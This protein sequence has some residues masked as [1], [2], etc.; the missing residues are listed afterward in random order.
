M[1]TLHVDLGKHWRG[2][3]NQAFLLLQGL[4]DRGH[5][6][7]LLTLR[8]SPLSR[9]AESAGIAVHEVPRTAARLWAAL[10][11]RKLLGGG[12]FDVLHLHDAH[13]LTV[14][15]LA[16][17][18]QRTSV[19]ASRRVAYALQADRF[20]LGRYRTTQRILAVSQFVAESVIASG[21]PRERVQ[22]VYDGVEIPSLPTPDFRRSARQ[23]WGVADDGELLGCVGYLLPEK[24]QEYLLRAL[25]MIR[26]KFPR[27]R[28]L[29]AGAG[30]C[31]PHLERLTRE[32]G[33]EAAVNFAG[34]VEDVAQVYP[35]LDVFVLPSL[36][37]P[38]GSS[39]LTAM[40]F[41]LPIVAV[42]KGA[43]PEVIYDGLT[44]LLVADPDPGQ[45]AAAIIRLLQDGAWAAHLGSAA[46]VTVQD[47]FTADCMVEQ[48]LRAY[49]QVLEERTHRRA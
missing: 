31:R 3:Q 34:L 42:G 4:R 39:L 20:A 40:G 7:E 26:A 2:G 36:A 43:M 11:L 41:A 12:R 21:V 17:A 22:V 37:E 35:A 15:W 48:T 25:P 14:A 5:P 49:Q 23:H 28:L 19:I 33:L 8:E 46:R 32:M 10:R 24:G 47:R 18:Y 45:I 13:G 29:L 38:L 9:R 6:S 30:P 1:K 16:R 27:C 44:G